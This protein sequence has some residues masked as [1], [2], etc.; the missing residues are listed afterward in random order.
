[1]SLHGYYDG[2]YDDGSD[3][4][5]VILISKINVSHHLH[6]HP[7]ASVSL[8]V[9]SVKLKGNENY[10]VLSCAMLLALEGKNKTGFI[11][12]SCRRAKHVWDELKETYDKADGSK[13]NQLIKLMQFLMGLDDTYMQIRSSILSRENILDVRSAYAIISNEESHMIA[14][15]SVSGTS[16]R[17][18]P[19][20]HYLTL[21]DVLVVPEYCVSLMSIHKVARDSKLVIAFDELK[22]YI[23]NRDL[24]VGKVPGAGRQFGGLYYFDGNQD[25]VLNVL[26]PNLLFENDKSDVM[27][28]TCQRAKQTREPYPL[29]D[30]A[31][32]QWNV[33]LTSALIESG[34]V[35]SKSN[36]SLFSKKFGDVFIGLLVYVDDII[37][38]VK[39]PWPIGVFKMGLGHVSR[40]GIGGRG[41][42]WFIFLGTFVT[43]YF[44]AIGPPIWITDDF[45]AVVFDLLAE[46]GMINCK[47]ADTPM[48]V[49]Q[50]LF[51]EKKAKLADGNRYQQLVAHINAAL[52]IV[53]YLK[54]TAG[55]G[56]LFR[57][58]GHLNIQ[59]YTDTDWAGDKGN[60]RSTSGY[61]SLVGGNLVS[62][63]GFPPRGST[64][65]MCDNKAAIQ[66]SENPIQ[67]DRTKHVEVD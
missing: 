37:I 65:I 53:R 42:R 5:N 32:R 66:I 8:T 20:T 36:C 10:Q 48:M 64:Q 35:Q 16:Q 11:N 50:K 61:F 44:M 39:Y 27:C 30:H 51:I 57:L 38:T 29:S 4:D 56:V 49:N 23:L 22:C 26:R 40:P 12:G 34:F 14:T 9:V 2:E 19:L 33:E 63:I 43:R 24:K 25:Q 59:M 21:F 58:N 54:G 45:E 60:R 62:E 18:M 52:R 55:H 6:L 67:H 31:P 3:V 28:E 15:G 46:I 7:N 47:P 13:H 1:M 17:N 41:S